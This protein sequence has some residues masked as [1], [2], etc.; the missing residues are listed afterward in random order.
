[1]SSVA[2]WPWVPTSHIQQCRGLE[3][4]ALSLVYPGS[5]SVFGRWPR[6]AFSEKQPRDPGI[7]PKS[8][9]LSNYRTVIHRT[10]LSYKFHK[11]VDVYI[12]YLY[13]NNGANIVAFSYNKSLQCIIR[14]YADYLSISYRTVPYHTI[15]IVYGGSSHRYRTVPY[16]RSTKITRFSNL[17]LVYFI[18]P[19]LFFFFIKSQ[20]PYNRTFV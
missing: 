18:V 8:K 6:K 3:L 15:G 17:A 9:E 20:Y 12:I 1:M 16:R 7:V 19:N 5:S 2:K 11:K 13:Y 14:P 4:A 10:I